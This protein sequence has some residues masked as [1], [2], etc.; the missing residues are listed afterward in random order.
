MNTRRICTAAIAAIGLGFGL[1]L[2]AAGIAHAQSYPSKPV[3]IILPYTPGSPNDV[4]VR[5]VAPYLSTRLGQPVVVDNRPGGGTTIGAKAVMT[6]EPDGHTLLFTNTPTHVIAPLISKSLTFDPI[7]DF[8][9]VAT[10]GSTILVLVIGPNVPA[11]TVQEFVAHAKANPGKLNFGFG[12]GTLPHL[13]GEL[14]KATTGA[15]IASIPYRGGAQAVTDLMGG[16]IDMNFGATV[17][18]APLAREGKLRA[19]A[20]TGPTRSRDLPDVPTM[21]ESGLPNVT[22][23]TYYGLMG[24]PGLSADVV[25]RINREVNEILKLPDLIASMEKLGFGSKGG[26]PQDFTALLAEQ[27]RTWAPIVKTVGFQME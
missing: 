1:G 4:L 7:T 24:P 21:A 15:D 3:K 16:R 23:V 5:L 12:Q 25:G 26:P 2:A 18:L 20:V 10:V 11:K 27:S 6:A 13:V 14:F 17:T 22:T 19:L 9:P 8:V